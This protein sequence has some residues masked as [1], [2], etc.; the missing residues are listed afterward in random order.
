MKDGRA[1]PRHRERRGD[2]STLIRISTQ[3]QALLAAVTRG[4]VAVLTTQERR[5]LAELIYA[6]ANLLGEPLPDDV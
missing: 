5:A 3:A 1:T 2:Q 6:L 4:E